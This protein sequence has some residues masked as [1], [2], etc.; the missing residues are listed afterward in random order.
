MQYTFNK[1]IAYSICSEHFCRCKKWLPNKLTYIR[2]TEQRHSIVLIQKEVIL[3]M[4]FYY[5]IRHQTFI[6]NDQ[7]VSFLW[8]LF[9]ENIYLI[10]FALQ[11]KGLNK[12]N[13]K[14]NDL[15]Y[16]G[17]WYPMQPMHHLVVDSDPFR[18]F[19]A[20][21]LEDQFHLFRLH[22]T[23]MWIHGIHHHPLNFTDV[24]DLFCPGRVYLQGIY[25]YI[26]LAKLQYFINLDFLK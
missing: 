4:I 21:T 19:S 15:F 22:Q 23:N 24:S 16:H 7:H 13:Y 6:Q 18:P 1:T 3:S 20:A 26:F 14:R 8:A 17:I 10:V 9:T 25:I 12:Q 2:M 5:L 11:C